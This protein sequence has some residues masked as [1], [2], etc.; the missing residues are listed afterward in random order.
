MGTIGR[1]CRQ[2]DCFELY[3]SGGTSRENFEDYIRRVLLKNFTAE[4]DRRPVLCLDGHKSHS[5]VSGLLADN[6][7]VF[8]LPP[9]SSPLNPIETEW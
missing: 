7:E 4:D 5:D 6:F 2:P 3:S 9:Q 8:K 1:G